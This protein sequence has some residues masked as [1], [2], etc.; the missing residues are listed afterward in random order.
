MKSHKLLQSSLLTSSPEIKSG[1][2]TVP[3]KRDADVEVPENRTS[4]V[5]RGKH[6]WGRG[7]SKTFK[8]LNES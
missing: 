1:P 6:E 2:K 8:H 7:V 3:T 5:L 4:H